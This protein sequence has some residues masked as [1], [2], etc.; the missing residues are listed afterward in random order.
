MAQRRQRARSIAPGLGGASS[1]AGPS[2]AASILPGPL[3]GGDAGR[4]GGSPRRGWTQASWPSARP[5]A[6]ARA[7]A[8]GLGRMRAKWAWAGLWASTSRSRRAPIASSR[9][10]PPRSRAARSW[11]LASNAYRG[12]PQ[13]PRAR[14]LLPPVPSGLDGGGA[15]IGATTGGRCRRSRGWSRRWQA[16]RRSALIRSAKGWVPSTTQRKP[17]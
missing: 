7:R 13:G 2:P 4:E 9:R 17:P 5:A 15:G 10:L 11:G 14:G 16:L 1:R 12:A 6:R 3:P 8:V